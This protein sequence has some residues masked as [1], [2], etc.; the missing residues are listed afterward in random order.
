M[1]L[2]FY[3]DSSVNRALKQMFISIGDDLRAVNSLSELNFSHTSFFFISVF[4]LPCFN[5][6]CLDLGE[7]I[8]STLPVSSSKSQSNLF[9]TQ[10]INLVIESDS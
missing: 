8:R 1:K 2:V 3:L 4:S 10:I 7:G 5:V 6:T 9:S